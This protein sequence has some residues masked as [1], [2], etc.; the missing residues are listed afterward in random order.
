MSVRVILAVFLGVWFPHQRRAGWLDTSVDTRVR[1]AL[2][3]GHPV[4]LNRLAGLGDGR[5]TIAMTAA[6]L[7]ACLATRRV[8]GAVLVAVAAP[9]AEWLTERLEPL[10]GRT[11]LGDCSLPRGHTTRTRQRGPQ[12]GRWLDEPP[13]TA[14]RASKGHD[15]R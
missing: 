13:G 2:L 15:L 8:R 1:A 14:G 7:V 5:P 10:T 3:G 4:L 9:V 11:L 12:A 6:L